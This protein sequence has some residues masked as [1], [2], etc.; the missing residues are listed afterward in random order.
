[1]RTITTLLLHTT[2]SHAIAQVL[3]DTIVMNFESGAT[4]QL[5]SVYPAGCWQ[6][7]AHHE[8]ARALDVPLY[9]GGRVKCGWLALESNHAT[10]S[11]LAFAAHL[12]LPLFPVF[13]DA[14][15]RIEPARNMAPSRRTR[16]IAERSKRSDAQSL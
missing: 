16:R 13:M 3:G 8:N 9:A 6:L 15:Q 14:L 10:R 12:L 7:G 4:L 11:G 1:M 5:D 2:A